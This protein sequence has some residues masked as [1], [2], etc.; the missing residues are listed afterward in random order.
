[1]CGLS[2]LYVCSR[3]MSIAFFFFFQAEDGIR[4]LTV[5]GVQT[6]ALPIF[7]IPPAL[8]G[9]LGNGVHEHGRLELISAGHRVLPR[10]P[11]SPHFPLVPV[12]L[13]HRASHNSLRIV[14][15]WLSTLSRRLEEDRIDTHPLQ[16]LTRS[17]IL[18]QR[19]N[20]RA[21]PTRSVHA[22]KAPVGPRHRSS[23]TSWKSGASVRSV[24]RVLN[25]NARSRCSP[26]TVGG[27][28]SIAP[29]WFRSRAA[30]T[31]PIP[32]MPG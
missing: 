11:C 22:A 5:T 13:K 15:N 7:A 24:A 27:K 8:G 18:R 17:H 30:V 21:S 26:S 12:S 20:S 29:Y 10:C 23:S 2:R 31:A 3:Y 6:C 25:N 28:V 14:L 1:M 16:T 19:S 9:K 32:A 4:D